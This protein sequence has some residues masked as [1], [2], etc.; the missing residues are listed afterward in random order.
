[1]VFL[2]QICFAFISVALAMMQKFMPGESYECSLNSKEE[3]A[4][5]FGQILAFL[6]LA[7]P[8]IA[9]VEGY[10]GNHISNAQFL[11]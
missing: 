5:G 10:M 2:L 3:S 6:L 7:L 4:M 11:A 1:M 8:L 9:A